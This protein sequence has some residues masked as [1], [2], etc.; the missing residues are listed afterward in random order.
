MSSDTKICEE[1]FT[2]YSLKHFL[3]GVASDVG[4]GGMVLGIIYFLSA[5]AT[6]YM[7]RKNRQNAL[8][9][10]E[11]AALRVIFPI[12]LPLL[13]FSALS[14]LFVGLVILFVKIN[15]RESNTWG[16]ALILA[17][18]YAFQHFSIEGTAFTLMQYG[19]GYQAFRNFVFWGL[20]WGLTTFLVTLV[21]YRHGVNN[22]LAF[23]LIFAW[24]WILLIFYSVLWTFPETK[25]YRRDAVRYF[26]RF[27]TFIRLT[28]IVSDAMYYFGNGLEDTSSVCI[29]SFLTLP[30]FVLFKPYVVYRSLLMDSVW[31]QGLKS[32]RRSR[33]GGGAGQ[34]KGGSRSLHRDLSD[35][36]SKMFFRI[37][38]GRDDPTS[39][40][41]APADDSENGEDE[42]S[43]SNQSSEVLSS[44]LASTSAPQ[45]VNGVSSKSHHSSRGKHSQNHSNNN[46]NSSSQK[47]V[48]QGNKY[49]TIQKPLDG[50]EVGF[51]EAQELAQEIDNIHKEGT[52]RLINSAYL[53]LDKPQKLLGAGSFSKVYAGYYKSFPVA[54]KMLFTQDINPEV[55]RRCSNEA[56]ILS[57]I[58]NCPNVVR[59][60][61]VSVF[62]PR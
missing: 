60:Y 36:V 17:T 58:S 47:R 24:N 57:E 9:G 18:A 3:P 19:C 40:Y 61:G 25:L 10:V 59:I 12:Y 11:G 44:L 28:V 21:Y 50:V 16:S 22:G 34:N 14:D 37:V 53:S 62:P 51:Q 20:G 41:P 33:G 43:N 23:A 7:I 31:W 30:I 42:E 1:V 45:V 5:G 8:L 38:T 49:E 35:S 2:A 13:F 27:W 26:S 54:L 56:K 46:N 6:L 32:N 55:I 4:I 48:L 15:F 52:I 39:Y 29:Y